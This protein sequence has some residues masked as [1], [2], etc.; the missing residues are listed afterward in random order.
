MKK[1]LASISCIVFLSVSFSCKDVLEEKP[2]D[3]YSPENSFVSYEDYQR[4]LTDLYAKVRTICYAGTEYK[5]YLTATDIAQDGRYQLTARFGGH[6]NYLV[7]TNSDVLLHWRSWYKIVTNA[8]TIISRVSNSSLTDDE[9]ILV[10]AEAKFF[11]AFAYR[12]LVYLWGGVP[13]VTEEITAPKTDFVRASKTD[14]LEQI[15]SDAT[16]AANNLPSI[17]QVTDGKVSNLVAQQLLAETYISLERY[18]DAIAAASAVIDDP[19]TDLMQNRFGS[20]AAQNPQDELLKFTQPGDV[21]WDLFRVGNQNRSS[22]NRE[23]LWVI[24]YEL[25]IPGGVLASAGGYA[26]GHTLER[27]AG[28]ASW[29]TLRDPDGEEGVIGVPMSDYNTGG[30]GVSLMMNTDF[31]LYDLWESDWDNDIRNA[32]HNIV[33]DL[34]YTNPA[35]T[36]YGKSA[37]ENPGSTLIE[38]PWRW[39]PHLSKVTTPGQHPDGVYEDKGLGII[40]NTAGALYRDRYMMRLAETYL[41]RAEAYL[42]KGDQQGAADNINEVR[43]RAEATPVEPGDVTLDYILD[44]R[45]RE[46]VYEEPRRITLHRTGKLVE[47]VRKY[48]AVNKDEIQDFHQ[49]WP[50]PYSEIEANKD[51]LLEQNLGY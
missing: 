15:I 51:A 22:G 25:D 6:T 4:G 10:A 5:P 35:S 47:R 50:I 16:E 21:Y 3:F 8:N 19:N 49:L 45:A 12:F 39:Y 11:R 46:L 2:L 44:E 26:H 24:Q 33:R 13:L 23:A 7:P 37:V 27:V 28:P 30:A 38:Q 18:D 17:N 31:F 42:G 20:M 29:L 14:V 41:L 36:W 43:R 32:P 48:N 40:K 34:V 9:K 1:I